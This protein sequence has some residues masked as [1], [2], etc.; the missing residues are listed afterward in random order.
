MLP[1]SRIDR[2]LGQAGRVVGRVSLPFDRDRETGEDIR[3]EESAGDDLRDG[4]CLGVPRR[5]YHDRAR[6]I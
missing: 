4:E 3:L 2:S 5:Q 1:Y 6:A